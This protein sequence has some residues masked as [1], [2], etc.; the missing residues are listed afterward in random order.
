VCVDASMI[1]M[2]SGERIAG[3]LGGS[4]SPSSS[5]L[6]RVPAPLSLTYGTRI[7]GRREASGVGGDG[8]PGPFDQSISWTLYAVSDPVETADTIEAAV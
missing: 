6:A 8:K 5:R 7:I 1:M 2:I 4:L 3:E